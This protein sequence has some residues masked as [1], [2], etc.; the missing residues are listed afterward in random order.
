MLTPKSNVKLGIKSSQGE[1]LRDD[2]DILRKWEEHI[3]EELYNDIREE[4]PIDETTG[5]VS[6]I[7]KEEMERAINSLAKGKSPGEDEIPAELLQAL[8]PSGK[9]QW[10]ILI[11]DIHTSGTRPK[12]F[13]VG[14]Y[15]HI[16]KV[17]KAT[18]CSDHR[19]IRLISQA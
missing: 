2:T 16:R 13:I 4:T 1:I 12:D 11:N 6:E 5:E 14:V 17:N 9:E 7:T 8:G 19:T 10:R 15:I 3:V 18:K